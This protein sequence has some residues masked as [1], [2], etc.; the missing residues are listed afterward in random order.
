MITRILSVLLALLLAGCSGGN[1]S[2]TSSANA[3]PSSSQVSQPHR[4][5]KA[6]VA[7]YQNAVQELYIA[8]FGRPADPNGLANFEAA[9]LSANAPTDILGLSQA[10]ATNAG[11]KALIDS[12]ETSAESQALYGAGSTTSFVQTVFQ[13]VLGRQ[14]A[15]SGLNFWVTAISS[16]SLTQGDAALAIMA[17][18][19]TNTSAQGL[20]DGQLINNRIAAATYFTAQLSALGDVAVYSGKA[21]AAAARAMLAGVI[22]TTTSTAYQGSAGTAI[23]GLVA[24]GSLGGVAAMGAAIPNTTVTLKDSA[25]N[26]RTTQTGSDGSFKFSLSGLTAPFLLAVT[27]GNVTLYSFASPTNATA[28]LNAYTTV[29][30]Q[31]FFQAAGSD[32]ATA[33]NATLSSA[34]LLPNAD[35]VAALLGPLQNNLQPFL[36]NAAVSGA[37]QFNPFTASFTAN[38]S[39]F[40]RVL[41]RTVVNAGLNSYT[42]DN[43]SGSTAGTLSS[44]VTLTVTPASGSTSASVSINAV[45]VNGSTSSSTQVSVPVAATSAQQTDLAAAEAGVLAMF[46]NLGEIGAG[47]STVTTAD[48]LPFVDPAFLDQGKNQAA[49]ATQLAQGQVG[50]IATST[51]SIYRVNRF[52]DGATKYLDAT[53]LVQFA[54]GQIGFFDANDNVNV[55]MVYKQAPGGNWVFYGQQT[56]ADAHVGLQQ[57]RCY[58]CQTQVTNTLDMQAQVSSATGAL[59]SASISGPANSLPDCTKNPSPLTQSAVTLNKDSGSYNGGDRYD[60]ACSQIDGGALAGTPPPAGTV[61]TFS[62]TPT[63]GS[64]SQST[65]VLNA[66]TNDNGDIVTINGTDLAAFAAANTP[67]KLAGA[68]LTVNFTLP[69][70]YAVLYSYITGFCSNASELNNG[71]GNSGGID[72]EGDVGNILPNVTSGTITIPTT[73]DGGTPAG[74]SVGVNFVGVNGETSLVVQNF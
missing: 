33:F 59:S 40:D 23:T 62:L 74:L 63:G 68:K 67:A 22:A 72:V 28:N 14:P 30:L 2:G 16:G 50:V 13:N 20:L 56:V 19:L 41:D 10:Y 43:G 27:S 12:F 58:G 17:G 70:T 8:Y 60:L 71:L 25:G 65:Y 26:V 46:Q 15:A 35:Q 39:G 11:V 49:Y 66:A 47:G 37:T 31:S 55:G 44:T 61:Y 34:S 36:A 53:V 18:G 6:A 7:D 64:P 1:S 48:V 51:I 38:G 32:V 52:I 57:Q 42:V 45:T 73:C 9:L 21:A 69:T 29:V 24:T 5:Q 4:A 54:N 3:S